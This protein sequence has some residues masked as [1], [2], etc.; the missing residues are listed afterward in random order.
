MSFLILILSLIARKTTSLTS[1]RLLLPLRTIETV[2][3]SWDTGKPDVVGSSADMP[4]GSH[5]MEG[6]SLLRGDGGGVRMAVAS[7]S[8]SS[9]A[10]SVAVA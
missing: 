10:D 8:S 9:S 6:V 2:W 4:D 5:I 3:G 1:F 7:S